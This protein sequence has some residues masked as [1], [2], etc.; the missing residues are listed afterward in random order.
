M[1]FSMKVSAA[2]AAQLAAAME[3]PVRSGHDDMDYAEF[4]LTGEERV[5]IS[6]G[7]HRNPVEWPTIFERVEGFSLSSKIVL[8]KEGDGWVLSFDGKR[9]S[10]YHWKLEEF[11][12]ANCDEIYDYE[13]SVQGM[14]PLEDLQSWFHRVTG[15]SSAEK[16]HPFDP[17]DGFGEADDFNRRF[18][19]A[20]G[21]LTRKGKLDGRR[22]KVYRDIIVADIMRKYGWRVAA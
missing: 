10:L 13:T 20:I 14:R 17:V 15:E 21:E 9:G 3:R 16:L 7:Y 22:L 2:V 18:Y 6:G 4:L 8:R 12:V 1:K 19:A 11:L 5:Q